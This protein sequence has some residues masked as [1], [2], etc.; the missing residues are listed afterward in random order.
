MVVMMENDNPVKIEVSYL[1]SLTPFIVKKIFFHNVQ[2][3]AWRMFLILDSGENIVLPINPE[4]PGQVLTKVQLESDLLE[5]K[6]E[7]SEEKAISTDR[8][9]RLEN[10]IDDLLKG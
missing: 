10:K 2:G 3:K 7:I 1:E 8:L 4:C 5:F 6:E 9:D